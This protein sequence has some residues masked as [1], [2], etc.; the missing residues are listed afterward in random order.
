MCVCVVRV[1]CEGGR[2]AVE[3]R[4]G[5]FAMIVS[6]VPAVILQPRTAFLPTRPV[7]S[8]I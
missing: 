7:S 2:G 4:D 1:C 3:R 8:G 5:R 6:K